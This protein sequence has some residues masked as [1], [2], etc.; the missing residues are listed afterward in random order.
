MAVA[1]QA[2]PPLGAV[3]IEKCSQYRI[4]GPTGIGDRAVC[5]KYSLCPFLFSPPR[6]SHGL[7]PSGSHRARILSH[8]LWRS[9][10]LGQNKPEGGMLWGQ[11]GINTSTFIKQRNITSLLV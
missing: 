8:S 1:I 10:L 9:A 3:A 4:L 7:N 5:N 11:E 2:G 6:A